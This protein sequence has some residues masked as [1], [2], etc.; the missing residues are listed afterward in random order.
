MAE[1]LHIQD[2]L[3][4]PCQGAW[5]VEDV[6]A[7]A[8]KPVAEPDRWLAPATTPGFTYV[9][10]VAQ[11]LSV[12]LCLSDG[13][14][15]WGDCVGVSYGGKAGRDPIYS[16][17]RGISEIKALHR[18]GALHGLL[19][20]EWRASLSKIEWSAL[21]R[22]TAYGLSQAL[23]RACAMAAKTTSAALVAR[24]WNL[25]PANKE[26]PIQ[27]SSGNARQVNAEKMIINRIGCLPH[28]QV[29]NI[30]EQVGPT[31][32]HLLAYAQWLARRI[33]ELGDRTWN[34]V[35]SLDVHG[36]LG[37]VFGS[38]PDRIAD[39]LC[40]LA[41]VLSPLELR[42]ESPVLGSNREETA[43]HLSKL[44]LAIQHRGRSNNIL[45][46]VD[47]FANTLA[48]IR[49][50]AESGSVDGVHIKMPDLG[51]IADSIEA[52]IVCKQRGIKTLLGGSCVE[53]ESNAQIAAH[54]ALAVSPDMVLA[55]PGMGVDEA[56]MLLR[57]EMRRT[58]SLLQIKSV[59]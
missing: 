48:D 54:L 31:G 55:K 3:V 32:E 34:P 37:K 47:E 18:S 44:K 21:S 7:L 52:V 57:N 5:Y 26:V 19:L 10:E 58:L 30:A 13:T 6:A 53:T 8:Q 20:G 36:A 40:E 42:I 29:D 46:F 16:S 23:L 2:V 14:V 15:A 11:V 1:P 17:Q 39:Y 4:V 22:A 33:K 24:E 51:S 49:F 43:Q 28:G 25:T 38:D 12:G 35:I 41:D 56:I 50:F 45:L 59:N 27:G 9:R